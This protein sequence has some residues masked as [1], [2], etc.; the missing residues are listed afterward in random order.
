MMEIPAEARPR[1][2]AGN[3][4]N[5]LEGLSVVTPQVGGR[6]AAIC[7][8]EEE[9]VFIRSALERGAFQRAIRDSAPDTRER[10]LLVDTR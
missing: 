1:I 7:L 8:R 9:E 6:I 5:S 2:G 10:Q 3:V 4:S